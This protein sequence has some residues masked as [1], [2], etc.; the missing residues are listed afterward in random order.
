[1]ICGKKPTSIYKKFSHTNEGNQKQ[2]MDVKTIQGS[3]EQA[4]FCKTLHRKL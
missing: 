4:V 2:Y 3:K 1:M